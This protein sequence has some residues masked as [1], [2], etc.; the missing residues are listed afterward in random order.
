M[1]LTMVQVV[2]VLGVCSDSGSDGSDEDEEDVV[3]VDIKDE[4]RDQDDFICRNL[5]NGERNSGQSCC[6]FLGV[7]RLGVIR[8]TSLYK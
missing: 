5:E 1:L 6:S 4:A 3:V 2:M 7:G 8:P